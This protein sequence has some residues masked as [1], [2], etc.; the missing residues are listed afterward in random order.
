MTK[1]EKE[2]ISKAIEFLKSED[3]WED[4]MLIL[5]KL[6]GRKRTMYDAL[7]EMEATSLKPLNALQNEGEKR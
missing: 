5:C 1:A 3:G 7:R 2:Q 6:A 4:G